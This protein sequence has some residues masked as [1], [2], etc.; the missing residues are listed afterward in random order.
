MKEV[1]QLQNYCEY[2]DFENWIFSTALVNFQ[3]ILRNAIT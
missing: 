2:L 3:D 1:I